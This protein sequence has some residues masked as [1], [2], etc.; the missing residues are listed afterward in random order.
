MILKY[1][2]LNHGQIMENWM[3]MKE[4]VGKPKYQSL[5]EEFAENKIYRMKMD[6]FSKTIFEAMML[7][8]TIKGRTLRAIDGG[9][10][11]EWYEVPPKCPLSVSHI[12]VLL[13]YCNNTKLQYEYKKMG[14]RERDSHQT[15]DDLKRWNREIAHFHRLLV[16]VVYLWGDRVTPNQVF[17]T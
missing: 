16:E 8:K 6:N 13:M 15:L 3:R 12:V 2:G 4:Y 9:G 7:M 11:N 17:Y 1:L 5:K 14:C 10:A